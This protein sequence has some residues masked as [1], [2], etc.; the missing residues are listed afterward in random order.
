MVE[1]TEA[2]YSENQKA[3]SGCKAK[4]VS[5]SG[6]KLIEKLGLFSLYCLLYLLGDQMTRIHRYKKSNL[7]LVKRKNTWPPPAIWMIETTKEKVSIT[8]KRE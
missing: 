5:E 7:K 8:A 3:F 1:F 6:F 4:K 2:L